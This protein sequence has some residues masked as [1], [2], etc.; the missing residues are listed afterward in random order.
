[1]DS[2]FAA[3]RL[4]DPIAHSSGMFGFIMG[5]IVGAVV[6]I[7][8]VAATVATGGAALAVVAAV[9]G[10]VAAT[11]GGA[12]AG[13]GIG[14]EYTSVTGAIATGAATVFINNKP[15]ARATM[16]PATLDVAACSDHQSP[17]FLAEGSKIVFIEDGAASRKGDRTVC[18]AKIS[19]GSPN[20]FIGTDPGVYRDISPEVPAILQQVALGM[21]IAGTAVALLAGGAAAFAAGGWCAVGT[22]GLETGLGMAGGWG[23]GKLGG[24]IGEALGG[25]KGR[26]WG[27]AIGGILGGIAGGYAGNK[28]GPRVF[29]GHP[30]DVATGELV[31][32]E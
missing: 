14:K 3:A 18:D 5:A 8:I 26:A 9:G 25:S 13:M 12:L 32:Q 7:A 1:M 27:E 20:V 10:A 30:I 11:G 15:A 22:F 6:G 24:A 2:A 28:L 31:T 17:Q 23:G 16:A 19:D 4:G 21:V 29:R